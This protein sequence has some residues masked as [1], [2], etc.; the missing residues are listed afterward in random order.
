MNLKEFYEKTEGNYGSVTTRF[1]GEKR[2]LKFTLK[3]P[4]DPSF[5]Q[6]EKALGEGDE[7]SAFRT[8]HTLKGVCQ[9]LS[10]DSLYVCAYAVCEALRSGNMDEARRLFPRLNDKYVATIDAVNQLK[11]TL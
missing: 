1:G 7:E 4:D 8:A 6:L 2:A 3:F 10:F 5:S 9:N 11:A